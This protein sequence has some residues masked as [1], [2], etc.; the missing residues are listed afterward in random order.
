M[1]ERIQSYCVTN[2]SEYC[3]GFRE[4]IR[5]SCEQEQGMFH[6]HSKVY[7]FYSKRKKEVADFEFCLL[8][9]RLSVLNNVHQ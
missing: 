7:K 6:S 3:Q 8:E 5:N 2:D 1:Q 9:E 4:F